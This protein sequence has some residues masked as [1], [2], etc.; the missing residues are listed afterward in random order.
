MLLTDVYD[1]HAAKWASAHGKKNISRNSELPSSVGATFDNYGDRSL[2][3]IGLNPRTK[4]VESNTY[5]WLKYANIKNAG[6]DIDHYRMMW[7]YFNF[8]EVK[9]LLID[10]NKI[11]DNGGSQIFLSS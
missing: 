7:Y 8:S 4:T 11:Y 2:K 5:I 10:K 6:F 3:I 9:P 1:V